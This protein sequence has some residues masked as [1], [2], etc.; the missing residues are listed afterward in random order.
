M[1]WKQYMSRKWKHPYWHNS[2]TGESVWKKPDEEEKKEDN[3]EILPPSRVTNPQ[4]QTRVTNPQTQPLVTQP[5]TQT[6]STYQTNTSDRR[7]HHERDNEFQ[8]YEVTNGFISTTI[9]ARDRY[10]AMEEMQAIRQSLD[11]HD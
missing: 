8:D 7:F 11:P 4:P 3:E 6:R 9:R 1:P 2:E 10:E 5:Q